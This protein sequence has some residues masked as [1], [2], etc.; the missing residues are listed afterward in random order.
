MSD[1]PAE[2][3]E[4][5]AVWIAW[6]SDP[7]L[8][9]AALSDA[10]AE[11]AALA[12]AI[13]D[14]DARGVP[15]GERLEILVHPDHPEAS[16][17]AHQALSGLGARFHPIRFGDIWLRDTG[18]IFVPDGGVLKAHVF[19][20][21][22][23]G[24]RYELDGDAG[25]S[26]RIADRAN[27]QTMIHSW[28]LEGGAVEFDGEDTVVTSR[29]CLLHPNRE[30]GASETEVTEMLKR[31]LEVEHVV[32]VSRG[33]KNDHTDGHIDTLARF[34]AP[35]IMVC[36]EPT[37]ASD[38]NRDALLAIAD[39]LRDAHDASGRG[40][41]LRTIPSPGAVFDDDGVLLP[42]SYANFYIANTTV[43]V[44]TYGSVHDEDAVARLA[45]CFPSR[46][47]VGCS[48][49]AILSGGGAFHCITQQQPRLL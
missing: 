43:V 24:R 38:P 9:G 48:A 35:G 33:L 37:D 32:W 8:W 5:E 18:P 11:F 17:R 21:N 10:Q 19:R 13:A 3:A 47:V 41:E 14:P 4:H 29:S 23:W 28:V 2:W 36:M 30:L 22:G 40:I 26:A 1:V 31:D 39:E 44:P 20:F 25:L 45:E 42:A 7:A 49:R 27:A 34:V 16:E 12:G 15:R 46:R 6:P